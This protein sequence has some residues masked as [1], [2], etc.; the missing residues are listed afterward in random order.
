M[1]DSVLNGFGLGASLIIA[2][3]AQN[4]FVLRQGIRREHV[5]IVVL[6]CAVSD[7]VLIALGTAG[8][9]VI[10]ERVG[11]L[12]TILRWAGVAYLLWFAIQSFRRAW[13]PGE[14]HEADDDASGTPHAHTRSA[15]VARTALA[16]TWLN[17]HVYLDT[18]VMLGNLANQHQPWRWWFA[19]GAGAA[20]ITWFTAL[21][22]G[23]RALAKPLGNPRTWRVLDLL[24][25]VVMVAIAIKL[26]I[27]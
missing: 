2:I 10:V 3:G 8:I 19:A 23:A 6:I 21:G 13:K 12:L 25:G 7:L 9:G 18:V 17:P 26:A 27:G 14:L 15:A 22:F 1:L 24:I 4:A 5:G 16:L 20:S 11:V